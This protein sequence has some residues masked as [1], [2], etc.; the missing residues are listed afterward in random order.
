MRRSLESLRTRSA[1]LALHDS[2]SS[3]AVPSPPGEGELTGR[4]HC[5]VVY[6]MD[7]S[8]TAVG[9]R[10]ARALRGVT[11]VPTE[12]HGRLWP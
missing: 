6:P 11:E 10:P 2:K 7:F 3:H 9:M 12:S 5:S 1:G 4:P 8:V